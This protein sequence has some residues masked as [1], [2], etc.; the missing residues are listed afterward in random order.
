MRLRLLV[1]ILQGLVLLAWFAVTGPA[2][3]QAV[4]GAEDGYFFSSDGV[5]LHYLEAG[6]MHAHTILLVPGWTTPGWIFATQIRAFSAHYRVI[7][8]DPRGQGTSE[9]ART[10]Y[11]PAR[12]GQDIGELIAQLGPDPV[13]LVAWS[14]GVLDTLAYVHRDSDRHLAGLVLVDNSIGEEPAPVVV[15]HFASRLPYELRMTRFVRGMFH[16]RQSEAYLETLTEAMLR[17]PEFAANELLA[18]PLPRSYW[19]EAV[20][21]TSKPLLYAIRPIWE[22]QAENLARRD[23]QAEIAVF[24]RAGHAL[25]VDD[26]GRFD[27]LVEDFIRRR[28][29]P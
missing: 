21:S 4:R 15:D 27:A 2:D 23:P 29:W 17:T 14:L 13:L 8:F 25:F 5:R 3:A 22:G 11:G 16:T 6:G 24:P 20:Y 18:Y 1:R 12:R 7:A 26:A 10:G 19:R 9:L 28:I